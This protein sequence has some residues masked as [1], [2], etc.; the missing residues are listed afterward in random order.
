MEGLKT[1]KPQARKGTVQDDVPPK[2]L[3]QCVDACGGINVEADI[4]VS[5]D[6]FDD[7]MVK[8]VV[9]NLKFSVKQPV[10]R[11]SWAS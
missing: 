9:E 10:M 6:D 5:E 3:T 2:G 7:G 1:L 8:C 4:L 11:L